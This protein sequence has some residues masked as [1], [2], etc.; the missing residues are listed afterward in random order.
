MT[1]LHE[2]GHKSNNLS[3]PAFGFGEKGDNDNFMY[4]IRK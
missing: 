3:D 2:I 1:V 4:T